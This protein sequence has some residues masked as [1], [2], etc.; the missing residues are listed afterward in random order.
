MKIK[1]ISDLRNY[2]Q[3][4]DDVSLGNPVYLTK[5]GHE[6]YVVFDIDEVEEIEESK[7]MLDLLFELQQG[8]QVGDVEGWLSHEEM[9][10]SFGV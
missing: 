10:R 5:N 2:N 3:V 7:A 1:L 8:K 4:L 6:K 9:R